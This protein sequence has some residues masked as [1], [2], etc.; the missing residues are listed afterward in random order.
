MTVVD[1]KGERTTE[2]LRHLLA[3]DVAKLKEPGKALYTAMLKPDG[4][5]IDDLI[6]YFFEPSRFRLIVNA[7]PTADFQALVEEAWE[8]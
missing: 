8:W 2:F 7:D 5:V 4:G 1:L 6:V 3:N